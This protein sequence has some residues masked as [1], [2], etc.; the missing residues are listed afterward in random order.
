MPAAEHTPTGVL[1]QEQRAFVDG[2]VEL[3]GWLE[4]RPDAVPVYSNR[5]LLAL[6]TNGAVED[7]AARHGFEV[8]YSDPEGNASANIQF[9]AITFHVYGYFDWDEHCE[10]AERRDAEAYAAKH[11]MTLVPADTDVPGGAS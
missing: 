1:S 8:A 7:F 4:T 10:R 9:G 11:G 6:H 5:I 2:L 3:A